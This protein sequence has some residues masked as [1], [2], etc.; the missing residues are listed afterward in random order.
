MRSN[1]Q[2]TRKVA[3]STLSVLALVI[4]VFFANE[5]R[6]EIFYLCGNFTQATS[7]SSVISQLNTATLSSYSITVVENGKTIT[8]SSWV[9]LHMA[10]CSVNIDPNGMVVSAAFSWGAT[11]S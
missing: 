10:Q 4:W 9:M 6:K 11:D 7:L 5:A 3:I 2:H 8:Q 1:F